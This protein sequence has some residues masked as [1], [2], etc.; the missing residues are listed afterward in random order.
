MRLSFRF[1]FFIVAALLACGGFG[2]YGQAQ[3]GSPHCQS[4]GSP[5]NGESQCWCENQIVRGEYRNLKHGYEVQV[6]DGIAELLACSGIGNGFRISLAH[7]ESGEDGSGGSEI[8][9]YGSEQPPETFQSIASRW[10]QQQREDSERVHA[11]DL[12]LD[13]P[14]QTSLSSLPAL[15]LKSSRTERSGRMVFEE[16]IASSPDKRTLYVVGM[17]TPADQYE[18]NEKL[19][20]EIE[21]GFRYAPAEKS[22]ISTPE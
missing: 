14:R 15:D 11:T 18:K 3:T 21:D 6:P 22:S 9:V 13:Q 5:P 19:L 10:P 7:P 16:I 12:Q 8:Y 20:T 2:S 17:L 4:D 1:E